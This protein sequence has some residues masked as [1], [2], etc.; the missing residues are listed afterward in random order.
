[1]EAVAA[2]TMLISRYKITV[3]EEPQFAHETFEQ[4]KER[5][6][7]TIPL[8]TLTYVEI[9]HCSHSF[10]VLIGFPKACKGS[11]GVYSQAM[12]WNM[13]TLYF[14]ICSRLVLW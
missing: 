12:K 9:S 2:L 11:V 5:I 6:L 4:K 14:D 1:M 8:L 10:L 7:R 13:P 3:K